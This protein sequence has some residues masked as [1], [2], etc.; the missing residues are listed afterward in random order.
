MRPALNRIRGKLAAGEKAYGIAV[1]LPSPEI[2]EAVGWTGYDFA[3]IDAEH[4]SLGFSEVR[5]LIR[6]ADAAGID[7]LVRV[8]NHDPSA[9]QQMLDLGAAGIIEPDVR[10][11]ADAEALVSAA[12]FG[13]AGTRGACPCGR[14][15][16]HLTRD[17]AADVRRMDADVLLFGI[18][19]HPD[20]VENVEAIAR[21]G[22]D[23]LL[24]GP[25]DLAMT[26]GLGGDVHHPQIRTMQKR[27]IEATRS[28]GIEYVSPNIAWED[29][30][31][32]TGSRIIP[33]TGD[34]VA[35]VTTFQRLLAEAQ[36]AP[37]PAPSIA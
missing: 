35:L 2:V 8:M 31:D 16:G 24:F 25:F 7:A 32:A 27:V 34:R 14:A 19:E 12:H 21:T 5:Q 18:I 29:D 23:G 6:A 1:Q 15:V 9:I 28:A 13:P 17:W 3:W 10:T 22:L 20:G 11:V 30:L 4:G 26:L 33:V 37:A 36:G